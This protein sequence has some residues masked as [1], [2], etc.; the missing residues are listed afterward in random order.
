MARFGTPVAPLRTGLNRVGR[1][2]IVTGA[3]FVIFCLSAVSVLSVV[4]PA[5]AESHGWDVATTGWIYPVFQTFQVAAGLLAGSLSDR[6]GPRPVLFWGGV[7][8]GAGWILTGFANSVPAVYFAFCVLG[9]IGNGFAY[10][11]SL[12]TAQRWYPDKRGAISGLLIAISNLATAAFS[13]VSASLLLPLVGAAATFKIIGV[14]ALIFTCGGALLTRNPQPGWQPENWQAPQG[15]SATAGSYGDLSPR[16]MLRTR[17]FYFLFVIFACAST[18][19]A[20]MISASSL[21]ARTQLFPD[22]SAPSAIAAGGLVVSLT[23]IAGAVGSFLGGAIFDRI[24]GHRSLVIIFTTTIIALIG[25]SMAPV[26]GFYICAAV[27]LGMAN[28]ALGAIYP[29]F[30]GQTFG[31]THLG[32]NWATMYWGYAV[33]TWVSAPLSTALYDE[34]A[35]RWAYQNTFYGAAL[36]SLAGL[37]LTLYLMLA[38]RLH[39]ATR[40]LFSILRVW[41]YARSR[42]N[43]ARAESRRG[44]R[45]SRQLPGT[46]IARR[47]RQA[48]TWLLQQAVPARMQKP[49]AQAGPEQRPAAEPRPATKPIAKPTAMPTAKPATRPDALQATQPAARQQPAPPAALPETQSAAYFGAQPARETKE[50]CLSCE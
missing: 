45:G 44:S 5:L 10:S 27:L 47:W 42:R 17:R 8:Y 23:T 19:G 33:A 49:G 9:G 7:L 35:G 20:M 16:Q 36:I 14:F 37:L 39:N 15:S 40:R 41:D 12:S 6:V 22:P 13:L 46:S 3:S 43:E 4:I 11:P 29:P 38:A 25:L 34:S 50:P 2:G 26:L 1:G 48:T 32:S 21:I 28:G 31:T 18:A 24:G 30:T